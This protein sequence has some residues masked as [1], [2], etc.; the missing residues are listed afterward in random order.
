MGTFV[1]LPKP[2]RETI[3]RLHLVR[4]GTIDYQSFADEST[5]IATNDRN[6]WGRRAPHLLHADNAIDR[7]AARIYFGE[8]HFDLSDIR[9]LDRFLSSLTIRHSRQVRFLTFRWEGSTYSCSQVF[10]RIGRLRNLQQLRIHVDEKVWV[11]E[12]IRRCPRLRWHESLGLSQQLNL[13]LLHRPGMN[14]LRD[15]CEIPDLQFLK[16]KASVGEESYAGGSIEGGCLETFLR[17]EINGC[18]RKRKGKFRFLDLPG[19]L[20]TRIY[21]L[22]LCSTGVL[23][24]INR[25]PTSVHAKASNISAE[26][27]ED[28]PRPDSALSLLRVNRSIHDEAVGIFYWKNDFVFSWP[29][30]LQCFLMSLG[31]QRLGYVRNITLFHKDHREGAMHTM[32]VTLNMLRRLPNLQKLHILLESGMARTLYWPHSANVRANPGRIHG[33]RTLFSLRGIRDVRLR[34]LELEG[35]LEEEVTD[36]FDSARQKEWKKQAHV[37]RHFNHGLALAQKGTVVDELYKEKWWHLSWY[38]DGKYPKLGDETCSDEE[39]CQ[40]PEACA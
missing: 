27:R 16:I 5:T 22:L 36:A 21:D 8:N 18:E 35:L 19:E 25:L 32:D 26:A 39:G 28:L 38:K 4:E 37:L 29:T 2:V 17:H 10:R 14:G 30:E 15:M 6:Y 11:R 9:D 13:L 33:M 7:E 12:Q 40:C 1:D 23:Y 31:T 24:P 20:R 3:Y 34:D